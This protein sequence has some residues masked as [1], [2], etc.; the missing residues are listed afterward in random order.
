MT[1]IPVDPQTRRVI[2]PSFEGLVDT[3]LATVR[4]WITQRRVTRSHAS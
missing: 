2:A 1:E 3:M 4:G